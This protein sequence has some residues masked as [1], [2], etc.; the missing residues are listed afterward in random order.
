MNRRCGRAEE[1]LAGAWYGRYDGGRTDSLAIPC[2]P[3]RVPS[4]RAVRAG[5]PGPAHRRHSAGRV[6]VRREF[7]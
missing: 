2:G 7:T 4:L 1:G 5:R 3:V 6:D